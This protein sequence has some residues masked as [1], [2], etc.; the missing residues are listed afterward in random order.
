MA[1]CAV[2]QGLVTFYLMGSKPVGAV[3]W[4]LFTSTIGVYNFSILFAKPPNPE[5]S[6]YKRVRWF[7][8][9]YRLM[10]TF[11]IVSLLSLVPLFFLLSTESRLLLI[12]LGAIS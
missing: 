4:L 11:T 12:F 7:F 8:S 2:A 5:R 6:Q 10:V 9:H 3:L 1:L